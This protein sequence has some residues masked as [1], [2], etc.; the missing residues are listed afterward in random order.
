MWEKGIA[1][2]EVGDKKGERGGRGTV[3]DNNSVTFENAVGFG[4]REVKAVCV[5]M[6]LNR[7]LH[8]KFAVTSEVHSVRPCQLTKAKESFETGE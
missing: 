5:V 1:G 3:M 2:L 7:V 8:G 6:P 4:V